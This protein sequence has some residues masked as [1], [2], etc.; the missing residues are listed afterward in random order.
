MHRE[1]SKGFKL[2][3]GRTIV[4]LTKLWGGGPWEKNSLKGSMEGSR[5][6]IKMATAH[7]QE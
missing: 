2:R 7:V 3:C 5:K 1:I 6:A 4:M